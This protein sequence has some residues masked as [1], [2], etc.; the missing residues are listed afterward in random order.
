MNPAGAVM[1]PSNSRTGL[2]KAGLV[3]PQRLFRDQDFELLEFAQEGLLEVGDEPRASS[4][5]KVEHGHDDDLIEI[6]AR[7]TLPDATQRELALLARQAA[8]VG[9]QASLDS[10]KHGPGKRAA[11]IVRQRQV[12]VIPPGGFSQL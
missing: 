7:V 11:G 4:L 8:E 10:F 9:Q 6:D 2:G 3:N 12:E 1:P 5:A